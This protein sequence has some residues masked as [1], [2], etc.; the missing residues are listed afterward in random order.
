MLRK[1]ATIGVVGIVLT[2]SVVFAAIAPSY[3]E[4]GGNGNNNNNNNKGQK[5]EICH[6]DSDVKQPYGSKRIE[7][8]T[9]AVGGRGNGNSDHS[10]HEGPVPS[11]ESE[12]QAIKNQHGQTGKWGDI[13]PPVDGVTNGMNWDTVGKAIWHNNC[14]YPKVATAD[15]EVLPATCSTAEQLKYKGVKNA[16]ETQ[17]STKDGVFGPR[18]YSVSFVAN[19]DSLFSGEKSSLT[20]SG[21]LKGVSDGR[22]CIPQAPL[23]ASASIKTIAATCESAEQLKYDGIDNASW[24]G[25]PDG[26]F[27][28]AYHVVAT[29]AN[30]A[31]F[32]AGDGVNGDR[33]AKSFDGT[34]NPILTEGCVLGDTD[35][36]PTTPPAE[37]TPV[38]TP[39]ETPTQQKAPAVLPDTSSATPLAFTAIIAATTGVILSAGYALRRTLAPKF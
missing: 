27:G 1:L 23:V 30:G 28:G 37:E 15:V 17:S 39:A 35:E 22:E 36:E 8:D 24:S 9:S 11:S 19:E 3:A 18:S 14:Q 20:F 32:I 34:L 29:A 2:L 5:V 4:K 6:R 16:T 25:T 21:Q 33:T 38:E 7:V 10:S 26:T 31:F 13:I 12:A